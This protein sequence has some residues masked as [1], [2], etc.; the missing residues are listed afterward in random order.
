M[1]RVPIGRSFVREILSDKTIMRIWGHCDDHTVPT[2]GKSLLWIAC[3][4]S[5]ERD[6]PFGDDHAF[7][8]LKK[9][10]S[11]QPLNLP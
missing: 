9:S 6:R 10:I 8:L 1:R 3:G 7:D 11:R 5:Y 2:N 4:F